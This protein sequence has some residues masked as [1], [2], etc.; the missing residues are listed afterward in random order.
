M[1]ETQHEQD[2]IGRRGLLRRASTVAAGVAGVGVVGA[3]GATPAQ[4]AAGDP[5]VQGAT[6]VVDAATTLRNTGARAA[7]RL[8]SVRTYDEGPGGEVQAEPA[9][10]L[11]PSGTTLSNVAEAGSIGMDVEGNIWIVTRTGTNGGNDRHVVHT[12]ANSNRIVPLVPQRVLDTRYASSRGLVRETGYLDAS[13]RLL[14]GRSISLRLTDHLYYADAVFGT[15]TVVQPTLGGFAQ[16]YPFG[17]TRPTDFSSINFA[18]NQ[19]VSNAFVCGIGSDQDMSSWATDVISIYTNRTTHLILDITAAVVGAG[20][21]NPR[22]AMPV[23]ANRIDV[24][25][26]AAWE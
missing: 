3:A 7:L 22:F 15:L 8:Q 6:N 11:M 16:V 1:P 9:L 17:T 26:K 2:S 24:G 25:G 23:R 4:A 13:G 20:R 12:T 18:P 14:A 21:V 19:I 5:V 10:Q